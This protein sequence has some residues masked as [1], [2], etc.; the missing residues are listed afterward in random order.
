MSAL[1]KLYDNKYLRDIDVQF[2][3]NMA[4][5]FDVPEAE[6]FYAV[7]FYAVSSAH[8]CLP[9][10]SLDT[11]PFYA[12]YED[13][14]KQVFSEANIRYLTDRGAVSDGEKQAAPII[15]QDGRLYLKSFYQHEKAISA[16]I[17]AA[18][19]KN[20]SYDDETL[21]LLINKYFKPED[22]SQKAAAINACLKSFCVISGG[23][24][25]G[26][27]TTVFRVLAMLS[28]LSDG[29]L[30]IAVCA[31]TGKAAARLTESILA[32]IENYSDESF[33]KN[34]PQKAVTLHKLL[35][36]TGDSEIS[37]Y[38]ADNPLP[39]DVVVTDEA[40]MVDLRMMSVL[41]KAMRPES[42][43][44]LLGD[45][46]QLAS[47][48]PGSVLG[49]ICLAA[50]TE[51]F[52]D[53]TANVFNACADVHVSSGGSELSDIT[54]QLKESRRFDSSKGIGLLAEA[55]RN[56]DGKTAFEVISDDK[57]G[58]IEFIDITKDPFT[59]M[60]ELSVEH[61]KTLASKPD[62]KEALDVLSGFAVLTPHVKGQTGT[63]GLNR[64][65]LAALYN[66]R[67]I[68]NTKKYFHGL[69]VLITENDYSL[70]LLN[71]SAGVV[72]NTGT[73]KAYFQD[74][75]RVRP[76]SVMRLPLW[77]P[78][79]AM[80]VHKSQGSEF[81]HVLFFLPETDSPVVTRELFYTAVTRARLKLTIV[82]SQD[83]IINCMYKKTERFSGLFR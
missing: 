46:D 13:E 70:R 25:T 41:V 56:G 81:D 74:E 83:A 32:N 6:L 9:I 79:F 44:I 53:Y 80:T 67:L 45:K 58:Q 52:T 59:A 61:F 22:G 72:M 78:L 82:S 8:T 68:D 15:F 64:L 12:G 66:K 18:S 73:L 4:T 71:G 42:R 57:T 65:A 26:K 40:S 60:K 31:P 33:I 75:D 69:P 62:P 48:Q 19:A 63:E 36:M 77:S 2:A 24:G 39:Y 50:D 7:L 23:P 51:K 30:S 21:K 27:T 34:I 20:H 14:L 35:K 76:V 1:Q 28:E 55:C 11:L 54:I 38:C 29:P 3:K 17:T 49:D 47:V 37:P 10:D 16:Y 43:L 5:V